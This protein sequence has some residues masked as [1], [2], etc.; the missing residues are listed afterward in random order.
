MRA[1]HP[2]LCGHFDVL[3]VADPSRAW[4]NGADQEGGGSYWSRLEAVVV[5]SKPLPLGCEYFWSRLEAVVVLP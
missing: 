3:Y 2:D 1:E 5:R 4:Y